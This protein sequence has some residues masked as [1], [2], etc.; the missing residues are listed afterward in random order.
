ML[1]AFYCANLDAPLLT[2]ILRD[3]VSFARA[4]DIRGRD[5]KLFTA[6]PV[7]QD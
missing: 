6:P 1:G 7:K 4:Y 3:G 5:L 2:E